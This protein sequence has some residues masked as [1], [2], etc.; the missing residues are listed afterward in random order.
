MPERDP[1]PAPK[2]PRFK[3]EE[4]ETAVANN[5]DSFF[6]AAAAPAVAT[7]VTV[8]SPQSMAETDHAMDFA[9]QY[10]RASA[11]PTPQFAAME[12]EPELKARPR[13]YAADF[14]DAPRRAM[15]QE[16]ARQEIVEREMARQDDRDNIDRDNRENHD[17]R[18]NIDRYMAEQVQGPEASL[19][20]EAAAEPERDLDVPTFMRRMKF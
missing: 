19:F 4:E 2:R 18:D 5:E 15:D 1:A 3:S 6:F 14:S 13:D 20:P 10:E 17:N 9:M 16:M 12:S 7:K 8:A 11:P